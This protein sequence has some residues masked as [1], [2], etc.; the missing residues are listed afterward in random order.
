[1]TDPSPAA[2]RWILHPTLLAAA[3]VLEVALANQVEP[4]GFARSLA[5]AVAAAAAL[6]LLAWGLTRDRW[7]GG[8]IATGLILA[9]VSLGPLGSLWQIGRD[10]LGGNG[11]IVLLG[12]ALVV[13]LAGPAYLLVRARRGGSPIRR[14]ATSVLNRLAGVLLVVVVISHAAPD[15]PSAVANL[16]RNKATVEVNPPEAELPDIY[17]VLM[18]GYPRTDML[19]SRL[20]ID[21]S[22]FLGE[23]RGLGFEVAPASRSNHVF[24]QV[25]LA[26]MFQMRHLEEVPELAP[27]IGTGGAHVSA[28]RDAMTQ[29]P[30]WAALHA[31]GYEVV[32]SLPGY[33]HVALR[34]V[35][36]RVLDHGE[37]NDLERSLLAG[38]WLLDLMTPFLP[39]IFAGPQHDRVLN[40][41]EDLERLAGESRTEPL[42]AWVHIP[43]PHLPLVVDRDGGVLPLEARRFDPPTVEGFGMTD[44]QLH[45]AYGDELSYLDERLLSAV[46]A[47]QGS[48]ADGR[49]DPVIVIFSDHGYY[50]DPEDLPARFGNFLAASTPGALG[51]TSGSPTPINLFPLLLNRYLGTDFALS[52]DRFFTSRGTQ[53]LLDLTEVGDQDASPAQ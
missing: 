46:R 28:L 18:D 43:A 39:D 16:T 6:T 21:N 51:L 10:L 20:G 33:E 34:A 15:L 25:T 17:M 35:A 48:A 1:M 4:P 26:S 19:A 9:A 29:G 31:A 14:P 36:D 53:A 11:A 27:L 12:V 44:A 24:T 50:Y 32:V 40:G 7:L 38:T 3:F 41:F 30:V 37:L 22:K 47:I 49:P 45:A 13:I 2:P 5:V 52:E 8:L 42:F 23:L